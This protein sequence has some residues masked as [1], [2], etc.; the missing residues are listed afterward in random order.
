[1]S[2]AQRWKTKERLVTENF[3]GQQKIYHLRVFGRNSDVARAS[4]LVE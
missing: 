4:E 1:M 2:N 3:F